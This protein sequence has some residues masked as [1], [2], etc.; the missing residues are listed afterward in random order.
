[1]EEQYHPEKLEA[2][3]QAYW[4]KHETFKAEEQAGKEKYY[5]LSM[6]PYPSGNL[7][8]GHA[9]NYTISDVLA[10]FHKMQGKNVL[11]PIGW[12]AFGL[13]AE[14]AAIQHKIPPAEWT[15]K[16]IAN[17]R[18]QLKSLG[19]GFDWSREISTCDP[20][21]YRWEQWFFIELY[22][23]GLVYRKK[24]MVNWDPVDQTV[25]ANEQVVDGR[26]WRSGALVEQR[27]IPQWFIKITHYADELLRDLDDKLQGWPEQVRT[28][29]RNWIGKSHGCEVRFNLTHSNDSITVFTTRV[30]TLYGCTYLAIAPQH[31][32]ALEAAKTNQ[33]LQAFITQCKHAKVA[34]ADLATQEKVGVDT[35]L[36]AEH[37]LTGETLPIWA[38]NFVLMNYGAGAV[39]SVPAHD[40]RDFEFARLY[41]LPMKQVIT[42]G[43]DNIDLTKEAYTAYGT[44]INS[45]EFSEQSSEQ[46]LK[47]IG[48]KLT[49]QYHGK[50][51]VNYRLRD[52][53]VSRQ[54]YWGTPIPII[55]CN[56]CGEVPVPEHELPVVLPTNL[57][58]DGSGSPLEKDASFYET[59]CPKCKQ[60]A[61]RETDTFD[62]FMESSWYFMRYTCPNENKAMLNKEA[63]NYWLPVDQY[64]G[65]IEHAVMHLL[66]ARFYHKAARDLGLVKSD[67]PFTKL[68]TQGMVLKDG[69]KMSKSKGNTVSP[70]ELLSKYGADTVRFFCM[71]AS[72]PEQSLEWSDQGVEGGYRYLK[73]LNKLVYDFSKAKGKTKLDLETLTPEQKDIRYIIHTT[74]GKVTDDIM[75]RQQ[76][77]TAIAAMM[78]L[79]NALSKAPHH[80]DNDHALMHEGL[81]AL[82][83]LLQPIVPHITHVLWKALGYHDDVANA[84]WPIPDHAAMQEDTLELA[85]Q[86]NGKLR[87]NIVVR[88]DSDNATIE[89]S[90][91]AAR[92]VKK[93][94]EGKSIKKIIIVPKRLVNIVVG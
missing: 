38:A 73:R 68:L 23:K 60:P 76:F 24:T 34:E 53:G 42:S 47:T 40:Q 11:H 45:D 37:P 51:T 32:L 88:V 17:M 43:E 7:H 36:T 39:M 29:Q 44:L 9:R 92:N 46:A 12:D 52:W 93:H 4:E 26:G 64:V 33:Q 75:R 10:R 63:A 59:T 69:A 85:V 28:M 31:P 81:S 8:M 71:F 2:Q 94:L 54:R 72:P 70:E 78:E 1:M 65:G 21:Y 15:E 62:T 57:A 90:A 50:P 14:N 79:T 19:L 41:G 82:I 18:R 84:S 83:R 5:C 30:D 22:K 80:S 6:L 56:A 74:I 61:K 66:Y 87:D 55:Y 48:E 77:N 3:V 86:V 25:L 58:P 35:G 67:E 16:N 27:E 13:P 49:H 20:S 89:A 91:L